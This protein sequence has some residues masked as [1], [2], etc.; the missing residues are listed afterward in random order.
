MD[1]MEEIALQLKELNA[2]TRKLLEVQGLQFALEPFRYITRK[3]RAGEAIPEVVSYYQLIAPA[4]TFTLVA[5]NPPGYVWIGIF[6]S[7]EVSQNGVFE[8]TGLMDDEI[9]PMSYVPRMVSHTINWSETIPFGHVIKENS[10]LIFTN[11]DIANQWIV[12]ES[13]GVFLRKDIWERDSRLMDLAAE[14]F[15]YPVPPPM[16]SP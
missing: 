7:I 13:M 1:P 14:K 9:I 16:P 15:M 2:T 5:T 4:A 3:L 6:Q 10:T 8:F 12:T 11:H